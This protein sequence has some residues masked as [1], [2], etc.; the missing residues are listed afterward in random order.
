MSVAA[1]LSLYAAALTWFCP[2]L[3]QRITY[4]GVAPRMGVAVWLTAIGTALAAWVGAIG[5][6]AMAL[7]ANIAHGTTVSFC[8][9]ILGLSDTA[10]G[11][12]RV[13]TTL[14]TVVAVVATIWVARRTI[15]GIRHLLVH[16][17]DHARTARMIGTPTDRPDVVVIPAE[18]PA[19]YCVAG[20]PHAIVL[21]SAAVQSLDLRQLA[22]VLAHE[23]A[24]IRGH[25]HQLLMVM[26]AMATALPRLP[27][28]PAG[29]SATTRLLEMCADDAAARRYGVSPLV[30][31]LVRLAGGPAAAVR[32]GAADTA[33]AARVTRLAQP[34]RPAE[35]WR[36]RLALTVTIAA[37]AIAPA[38]VSLLCAH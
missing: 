37:T 23:D 35:R 12:G 33:V 30:E 11:P 18:R 17:G 22:A 13:P 29:A 3:L 20:R 19:A 9:D 5:A 31:S 24:H 36:H 28:F 21:T 6:A 34:A 8:L 38:M 26:R 7:A 25:H 27:L 32:L 1:C 2:P 14:A 16:S 10:A 15:T 4:H